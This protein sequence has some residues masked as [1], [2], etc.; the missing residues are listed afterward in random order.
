MRKS[1]GH[2]WLQLAFQRLQ[3]VK[4]GSE[5]C[6]TTPENTVPDAIQFGSTKRDVGEAKACS[7]VEKAHREPTGV[8]KDED[9]LLDGSS[10]ASKW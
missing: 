3:C 4:L 2:T 5:T 9:V 7:C 8:E 6:N 1:K 10:P